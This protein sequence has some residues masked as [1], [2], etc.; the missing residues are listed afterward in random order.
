MLT[1]VFGPW[2]EVHAEGA[3]GLGVLGGVLSGRQ[4]HRQRVLGQ[5]REDMGCR[6]GHE[7]E[8]SCFDLVLSFC[9]F[10]H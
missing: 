9:Y 10:V 2:A 4:A 3:L 1:S 7:G 5:D 6:D 8:S